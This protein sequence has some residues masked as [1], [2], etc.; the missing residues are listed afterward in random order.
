M[1]MNVESIATDNRV[2]LPACGA[3]CSVQPA[4]NDKISSNE[5]ITFKSTLNII[6][7]FRRLIMRD[8]EDLFI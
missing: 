6:Y 8:Q 4:P 3:D 5:Q 1:G 7:P 2:F